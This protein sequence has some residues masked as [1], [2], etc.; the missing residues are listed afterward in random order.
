[1]ETRPAGPHVAVTFDVDGPTNWIGTLGTTAAGSVSRGEFEPIGIRRLL[2]LLR[3]FGIRAT[4]FV[5]GSTALLYPRSMETIVGDGHEIAHHGWV[6][7]NPSRLDLAD[8][9]AVLE[10]GL[11][12]IQRVTT[13]TPVGYRSPGWDNSP[14][15]IGLLLE[16][17]FEYDSSLMG[18]DFEPYWC[19]IGDTASADEGF[20]YGRPVPIVELPV[21]W[22][23]DDFPYFEPVT[24]AGLSLTG[25][26]PPSSVLEV[27]R[28]ELD[29]L[30][31]EVKDGVMLLTLHPQV[32]GRGYRITML[33]NFLEYVQ[34]KPS[35][36]FTTC[37]E[38]TRA[39]RDGKQPSLPLD[40]P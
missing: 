20:A 32:I 34:S 17:G 19:R 14:N 39:W 12:G 27:W 18:G 22:H 7:E 24:I 21:T 29:Y 10:R 38:Y 2:P 1:M 23:L 9:R 28:A 8:E 31:D 30:C 33:R 3:E 15:T 35:I 40:G 26:R 5:P 6:H 4:F 11:E 25:L 36:T 37:T 13:V 16:H